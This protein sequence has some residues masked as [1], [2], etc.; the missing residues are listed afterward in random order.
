[1]HRVYKSLS[2]SSWP[3]DCAEIRART[4]RPVNP[5]QGGRWSG[6]GDGERRG[7]NLDDGG[8]ASAYVR[9]MNATVW[10][11]ECGPRLSVNSN[12]FRRCHVGL[13]RFGS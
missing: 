1:V 5:V 9:E 13:D 11:T 4:V 2:Q 10:V 8:D 6:R 7:G 3:F 12:A